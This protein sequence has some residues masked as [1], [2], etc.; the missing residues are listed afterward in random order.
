MDE[1]GFTT[2]RLCHHRD[3]LELVENGV[4]RNL[5]WFLG[6]LSESP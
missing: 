2:Y 3:T 1:Q 4:R 5:G 6:S